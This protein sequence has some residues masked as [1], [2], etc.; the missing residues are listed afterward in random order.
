MFAAV[1][2]IASIIGL[3]ALI[4]SYRHETA[5]ARRTLRSAL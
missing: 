1:L 5:Y 4:H 3:W 2:L